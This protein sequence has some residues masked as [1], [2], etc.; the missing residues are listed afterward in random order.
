M[1]LPLRQQIVSNANDD[2]PEPESPVITTQFLSRNL[3]IYVLLWT[4]APR[5]Y[6]IV[7]YSNIG[8]LQKQLVTLIV[9]F[10]N[11]L[12]LCVKMGIEKGIKSA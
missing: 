6:C 3:F 1:A 4:L 11:R 7:L 5:T 10:Q 2:F 8:S 9:F 12:E